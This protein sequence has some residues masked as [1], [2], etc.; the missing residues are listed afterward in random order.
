VQCYHYTKKTVD[1]SLE[2]MISV[3]KYES[4]NPTIENTN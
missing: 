4:S 1:S 3:L 2:H